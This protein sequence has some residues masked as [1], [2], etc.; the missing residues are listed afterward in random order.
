MTD[1]P[2]D[3]IE[4]DEVTLLALARAADAGE[5]PSP[6]VKQHLMER[7]YSTAGDT[8]PAGFRILESADGWLPHPV[9]GIKM[10]VLSLD[11]QRNC[12]TL[13]FDV[14]PGVRFPQHHHDAAE[15]CYVVSGSLYAYGRRLVAGDFIHADGE[16]DHDELWTE[17]GCR[18]LLVVQPEDYF[19]EP[20]RR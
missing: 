16:T 4:F 12:A 3:P 10:K 19:P 9:P 14:D 8:L 15:E 1:D 5:I 6:R 2:N 13:I 11:R 18:V 20:V 7:I 17:E